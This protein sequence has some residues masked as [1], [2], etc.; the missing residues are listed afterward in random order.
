MDKLIITT[1]YSSLRTVDERVKDSPIFCALKIN[2]TAEFVNFDK[3]IILV[4]DRKK[5]D[6]GDCGDRERRDCGNCRGWWENF[7][8]Q[9]NKNEVWYVIYHSRGIKPA[10]EAG[11]FESREGWH[12][13]NCPVY[14][15][16]VSILLDEADN[17]KERII[18]EIF[19]PDLEK[20]LESFHKQL[21]QNK[22]TQR[23]PKTAL[24]KT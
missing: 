17:K 7:T 22:K 11:I 18:N 5:D 15:K 21:H 10:K 8:K 23:K 14:G 12:D 13:S 24:V 1:N 3:E 2:G 16:T 20:R 9:K 4:W 19:K 6:C